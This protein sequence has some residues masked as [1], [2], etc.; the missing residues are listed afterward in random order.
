M[1]AFQTSLARAAMW[2][3][4]GSAVSILFS[5]MISQTLLALALAS[6]LLSGVKL[7]LPPIWIPLGL[8]LLGTL[9]SLFLADNPA[10]GLPQIRKFYVFTM[11]LAMFSTI[12]DQISVRRLFLCWAGVGAGAA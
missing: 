10:A 9:I 11:L 6:L 1:T 5:I 7:R 4:F 3:S 8:F 12:R 2:L